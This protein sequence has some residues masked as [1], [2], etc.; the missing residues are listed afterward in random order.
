[1]SRKEFAV[2]EELLRADGGCVSAED[3][4]ERVWDE[5]MDPFTTIV[6]GTIMGLRR[7]LGDPPIVETVA[8]IGY[9]IP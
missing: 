1:L 8:G 2:L 4:L 9:R 5:N 6:R 3:L 7:K